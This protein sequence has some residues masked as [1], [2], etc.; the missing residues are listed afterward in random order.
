MLKVPL[1]FIARLV[2]VLSARVMLQLANRQEAEGLVIVDLTAGQHASELF[3]TVEKALRCIR[4][5]DP[6][7]F[8]RMRRDVSRIAVMESPGSAGEYWREYKAVALEI[9]HLR[10]ERLGGI[11]MTIVHEATHARIQHWG[12]RVGIDPARVER[13]CVKQEIA[14]AQKLPGSELLIHGA[15]MKLKTEWWLHTSDSRHFDLR[16]E[17]AGAPQWLRLILR[18]VYR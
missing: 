11:C 2:R 1:R 12:V 17:R 4:N 10:Q 5:T 3:D 16:L 9:E 13:A 14:F 18:W 6:V 15:M 8:H 7:R